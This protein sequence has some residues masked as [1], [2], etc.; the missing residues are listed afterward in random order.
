MP[1][2][3]VPM[4]IFAVHITHFVGNMYRD[5]ALYKR[6][7]HTLLSQWSDK[8]IGRFYSMD[9]EMLLVSVG[10]AQGLTVKTSMILQADS[11]SGLL[12]S[13]AFGKEEVLRL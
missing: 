13:Q 3:L 8:R 2:S 6:W 1:A 7:R 5:A 4:Y 11:G 10:F 12:T 9:V